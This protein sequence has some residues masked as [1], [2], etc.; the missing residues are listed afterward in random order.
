[1]SVRDPKYLEL[2]NFITKHL[3]FEYKRTSG[4]HE[5]YEGMHNGKLRNVTLDKN[6]DKLDPRIKKNNVSSMWKQMGYTDKKKFLND[7]GQYC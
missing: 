6:H 7:L 1:M 3:R 4:T 2:Y 5:M